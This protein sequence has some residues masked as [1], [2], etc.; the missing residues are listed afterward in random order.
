[1]FNIYGNKTEFKQW[2]Q[3]QM[4]T[5]DDMRV[6]DKVTFHD[7][8]G[9]TVIMT[10]YNHNGT[11]VADVPNTMLATPYDVVV[12][13]GNGAAMVAEERT[14]L[15][16]M[17]T[18][19]PADYNF[20][21][22]RPAPMS[23]EKR[24]EALE[25]GSFKL[26]D[27]YP[28]E[29]E[30]NILIEWDG[31]TEGLEQFNNNY[32]KIS[33]E[34]LT[35]EKLIGA[36]LSYVD[37]YGEKGTLVLTETDMEETATGVTISEPYNKNIVV[38]STEISTFAVKT[39]PTSLGV[40]VEDNIKSF[41]LE[42][43]IS[44]IHTIDPKY[45]PEGYP[46]EVALYDI[47]WDGN[48]EG[49][50]NFTYNKFV[51]YKI[52]D[53]VLTSEQLIGSSVFVSGVDENEIFAEAGLPN[54]FS[55]E[56]SMVMSFEDGAGYMVESVTG[57]P[58]IISS[59]AVN[60]ADVTLPSI[61]TYVL[62]VAE[63]TTLGNITF[64]SPVF[65]S[66]LTKSTIQPMAI[67]FLPKITI[68]QDGYDDAAAGVAAAAAPN[69]TCTAN[70]TYAE[71]LQALQARN[72]PPIELYHH[73]LINVVIGRSDCLGVSFVSYED[74]ADVYIRLNFNINGTPYVAVWEESGDISMTIDA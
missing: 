51:L 15:M 16:V 64:T 6:G 61:G 56:S 33:D 72:V 1:M 58:I 49:V 50:D 31:N 41:R 59:S 60:V 4:V 8:T 69:Y 22:N 7:S 55:I 5:N 19:K 71:L 48:I 11:V 27:G 30:Q 17:P 13:L 32:F 57:I 35:K 54:T 2:E 62:Y 25:A 68:V 63:G 29:E 43:K 73:G 23:L 39:V 46:R 12:T 24:V 26:P 70:A 9:H 52:S 3:G 74:G 18:E 65:A 14:K 28:Y 21:D 47:L 40:W 44:T 37:T 10:A 42:K 38:N 34:V 45:M 36:T 53:D 20:I 67:E 66:R